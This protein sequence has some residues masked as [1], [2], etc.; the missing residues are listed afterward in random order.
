MINYRILTT[1]IL[2]GGVAGLLLTSCSSGTAD[3]NGK[4]NSARPLGVPAA[5]QSTQIDTI[6]KRGTIRVGVLAEY[7]WLVAGAKAADQYAGPSW[8]LAMDY[9]N[10]L[11]VK[12]EVV[13]V[14]NDTKVPL[15]QSGGVDITIAP[16]SETPERDKII[17][18]VLYSKSSVCLYGLKTNPKVAAE[19]TVAD[20]Q[21]AKGISFAYFVGQPVGPFLTTTFPSAEVHSVQ[22]SGSDAPIEELLS[23]RADF[24]PADAGKAAVLVNAHKDLVTVPRDCANSDL[25]PTPVGQ[26]VAKTDKVFVNYLRGIAKAKA[27]AIHQVEL[28]LV[29]AAMKDPSKAN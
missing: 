16:L 29:A 2:A 21:K 8:A 9:A 12:L 10:A 3:T 18:F 25:L 22:G 14:S 13:P 1:A 6:L 11:G 24:V 26:G 20:L 4:A 5:G 15:V 19:K 28:D 27:S 7:P 17:D 23:S